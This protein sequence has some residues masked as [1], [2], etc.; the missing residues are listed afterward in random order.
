MHAARGSNWKLWVLIII[1]VLAILVL[2]F[3][4][5]QYF[6]PG[7]LNLDLDLGFGTRQTE[8][9]P[10]LSTS[11]AAQDAAGKSVSDSVTLSEGTERPDIAA[12]DAELLLLNIDWTG[13]REA[14]FPLILS[15]QNPNFTDGDGLAVYHKGASGWELNG[16][17][18]IANNTV[19][20]MTN[21]LSP[22]AFE[23]ISSS[24]PA[25]TLTPEPSP[26]PE[27]EPTPEPTPTPFVIDYGSFGRV[28]T[29]TFVQAD[30]FEE[31]GAYVIAIVD[32]PTAGTAGEAVT[33]FDAGA[34]QAP[35][36]GH[37]LLNYDG[38]TMRTFDVTLTKDAGGRYSIADPVVRGM[39]WNVADSDGFGGTTRFA[40]ANNDNYLN[41][42]EKDE[43]VILNDNASRTRWLYETI[44]YKNKDNKEVSIQTLTYRET[45]ASEYY[46]SAM[47]YN[48]ADGMKF[49]SVKNKDKALPI[50]I[51][52][53]LQLAEGE[54]FTG[55]VIL[56]GTP[57]ALAGLDATPE[58]TP[59]ATPANQNV[60]PV[61]SAPAATSTPAPTAAPQ[62]TAPPEYTIAPQPTEAPP[63][64]TAAP[65]AETPSG[66]SPA[67]GSD[68]GS[69]PASGTDG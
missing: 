25:P 68:S 47:S 48:D 60:I 29:G 59:T 49:T 13:K 62:P 40:L 33:F 12:P 7:L 69:A 63:A 64:E 54:Y 39:L 55:T 46:I 1:L 38:K 26:T 43:N 53:H 42:D 41:L 52:R 21:S 24:A 10:V 4:L 32:D 6:M 27:P 14:S 66:G 35:I 31:D 36:I 9:V 58:P 45:T 17:Y 34:A 65:P 18:L 28:V 19:S 16:T 3:L 30:A 15:V 20:F 37:V 67:S 23:I 56:T 57:D 22:F 61:T 11:V 50:V 2:G 44:T 5:V 51:F 8:Q